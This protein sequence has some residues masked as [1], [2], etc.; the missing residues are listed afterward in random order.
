MSFWL[1]AVVSDYLL[2]LNG[3]RKDKRY[4][5]VKEQSREFLLYPLKVVAFIITLSGLFA[6]VIEVRHFSGHSLEVY[7]VRLSATL[8]SFI[9]LLLLHTS[10]G[11]KRPFVLVHILLLA[12]IISSAIMIYIIPSTLV[13]NS[14]ILGLMIFTS[15]LF[16]SWEVRN[17][18]IIAIYYNIVF[19]AAI[20]LSDQ[21][22]YFLP[23]MYE[24]VLFVLFLS[25]ISVIGAAVNFK[26][27]MDVA[28]KSIKVEE[29]EKKYK[30]I[31]NNSAEGIYQSTESGKLITA[32]QALISLLG[33]ESFEEMQKINLSEV[34]EDPEERTLF[35]ETLRKEK[36]IDN[37]ILH[38]RKKNGE[39]TIVK[40]NARYINDESTNQLYLEGSMRDITMQVHAEIARDN[41]VKELQ[42]EKNKS[43][44][45]AKEATEASNIKGQF[46]ANM[47]HEIRTPMNGIIGFL[48]LIEKG[49]YRDNEELKQFA[50]NAK[51]SADTLLDIINDILDYSKIESGKMKLEFV[52]FH[53]ETIVNDSIAVVSGKAMEKGI[54][55]KKIIDTKLPQTLNGDPIK[56]K[57]IF[58]NLLSN[59]IKFS[60]NGDVKISL[61]MTERKEKKIILNASVE[62]QGV[63]IPQ[64]KINILFQPFSQIDNSHSRKYGGTGLGLAICKEFVT[65]MNGNINVESIE[66]SGS[67]F[68]FTAEFEE[69]ET[70]K[71]LKPPSIDSSVDEMEKNIPAGLVLPVKDIRSKYKVL[72]AEDNL[73]NQKVVTKILQDSGYRLQSVM[74]GAEAVEAVK[75]NNY[76][77]ILMDIQMPQMNGFEATAQIRQLDGEK[78]KIP[79]IAL[80]AHALSGDREK[81]LAEGMNDYL[82]KPLRI[83][84]L[85]ALIDKWLN[86]RSEAIKSTAEI[87]S[88]MGLFNYEQL[89]KMSAGDEDFKKELMTTYFID[90]AVR[91]ELLEEYL[92][93][94]QLDDSKREAHSIKGASNIIGCIK[95]GETSHNIELHCSRNDLV[96]AKKELLEL[97]KYFKYTR[98]LLSEYS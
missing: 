17:Q 48:D 62:D 23:N 36:I 18:I 1:G 47:S 26:L 53:L 59:A 24:S 69:V 88:S 12:I 9:T 16:L 5:W 39:Q 31:F 64:N 37:H 96:S 14:Q 98:Q 4:V 92:K 93:K 81:C 82:T 71:D 43:D 72:L 91:L 13:I 68:Y 78:A 44:R 11:K 86:V 10:L 6:M 90:T 66:G 42:E 65:M 50:N 67:K 54:Q 8:I 60:E 94:N 30:D 84:E 87:D 28:E 45:L 41:A 83:N 95:I 38:L 76:D 7:L 79:I 89:D 19:A 3:N 25:G 35:I 33:Y 52:P 73:V 32:N 2:E 27:K 15:A 29:S 85:I 80:T 63:G 57:Q 70:S 46:L 58:I 51:S 40:I 20:L 34:Y 21:S 55:V 75:G 22:I 74:N 49:T 56:L 61:S 77:I 97:K